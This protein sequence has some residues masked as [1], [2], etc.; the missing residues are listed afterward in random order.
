MNYKY[1][2][3]PL[4]RG[5]LLALWSK[6]KIY[7]DLKLY[8]ISERGEKL[9]MKILSYRDSLTLLNALINYLKDIKRREKGIEKRRKG[10][11]VQEVLEL[12][13]LEKPTK[14]L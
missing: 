9:D 12:E 3:L 4:E 1:V 5:F 11:K 14:E 8:F 10:V 13:V 7:P 6:D 2:L